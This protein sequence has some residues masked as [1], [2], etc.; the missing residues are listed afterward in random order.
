MNLEG[1]SH[2]PSLWILIRKA[3]RISK[4]SSQQAKVLNL[5]NRV[6]DRWLSRISS[7]VKLSK[8]PTL[9]SAK[10]TAGGYSSRY[11]NSHTP[12]TWCFH[13]PKIIFC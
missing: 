6:P 1:A 13:K 12:F 3:W 8:N 10:S 9:L 2:P 7:H 5:W 11:R 4:Y